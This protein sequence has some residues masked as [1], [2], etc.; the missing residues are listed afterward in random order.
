MMLTDGR[1]ALSTDAHTCGA[2]SVSTRPHGDL[3]H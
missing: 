3:L 2:M 1:T